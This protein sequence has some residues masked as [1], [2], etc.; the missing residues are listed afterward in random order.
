M[1]NNPLTYVLTSA[2]LYATGHRWL[3]SLD[4]YNVKLKYRSGKTKGDAD[5]L[6]RRP[7]ETVQLFPDAVNSICQAFH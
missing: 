6:S 3:A 7:Q 4:I 2:K 1:D 5:G